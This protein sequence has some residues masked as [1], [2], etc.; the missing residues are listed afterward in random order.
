MREKTKICRVC[1]QTIPDSKTYFKIKERIVYP[2]LDGNW[3]AMNKVY[4]CETCIRK[5]REIVK[6]EA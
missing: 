3:W 5:I 2:D 4:I 6:T 1:H